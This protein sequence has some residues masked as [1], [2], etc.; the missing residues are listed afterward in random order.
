MVCWHKDRRVVD[1]AKGCG[2]TL[3][4]C[5]YSADVRGFE[6]LICLLDESAGEFVIVLSPSFSSSALLV[7]SRVRGFQLAYAWVHAVLAS[8]MR[9]ST[10]AAV[11]WMQFF[12]SETEGIDP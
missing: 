12:L 9:Q 2:S 6:P 7:F 3:R 4:H 10:A 1:A 5:R 8:P 11:S